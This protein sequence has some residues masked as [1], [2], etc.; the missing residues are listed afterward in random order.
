MK[1]PHIGIFTRRAPIPLR[2]IAFRP[3]PAP[4]PKREIALPPQDRKH[5]VHPL[6]H[7]WLRFKNTFVQEASAKDAFCE[8]DC[9]KPQGTEGEW[10][11]CERRLK[12]VAQQK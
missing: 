1:A 3:Y 9:S 11:T 10:N 8:F 2:P 6:L 4:A 5:W 12:N 7:L